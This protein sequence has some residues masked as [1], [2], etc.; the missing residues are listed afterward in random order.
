MCLAQQDKTE[1]A[2]RSR[3][4]G[5]YVPCHQILPYHGHSQ[6]NLFSLITDKTFSVA[7][8]IAVYFFCSLKVADFQNWAFN[9]VLLR[10]LRMEIVPESE[11]CLSV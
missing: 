11:F 8:F 1:N 5:D 4:S 2:G 7:E 9:S 10:L 3:Q 6:F